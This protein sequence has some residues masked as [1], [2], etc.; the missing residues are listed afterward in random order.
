MKGG[1]EATNGSGVTQF[2][3]GEPKSLN[4]SFCSPDGECVIPFAIAHSI[5]A[6]HFLPTPYSL[7]T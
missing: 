4:P 1:N 7:K 6:F 3:E 5:T 2:A